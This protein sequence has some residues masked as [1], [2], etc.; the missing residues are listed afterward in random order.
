MASGLDGV[1]AAETVLSLVDGANGRLVV[2]GKE[3]AE[4]VPKY[5]FEGT[6]ALL[7]DGFVPEGGNRI[8]VQAGLGTAREAAFA[9]VSA[10][11]AAARGLPPIE[12]LRVGLALLGDAEPSPHYLLATGALPVFL[13]ALLRAADGKSPVAPDA[14]LT[15]AADFLRMLRDAPAPAAEAAALDAYLTTVAEHGLNA[16]TFT[17]R[18]VASTRAGTISAVLGALC[19]LKGPLH[20][21]APEPVLDMLDEIGT[22]ERARPWLEA[23]ISKGE[24]LMG[25][26][27]RIYKVRDPRA[28]VLKQVV[29][30]MPRSGNRIA[31]AE[32]VE[33]EALA[34]LK[35]LKPGRKLETNVEF[36]TALLLDAVGLP[37]QAFTPV[38]AVARAVGW[39]AHIMEQDRLGRLVR[40]ESRY[41]GP[42]LATAA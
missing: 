15:T 33:R 28:D 10:L 13:A 30:G 16:S 21:G 7:W 26:G 20:G 1:V 24:R 25:F 4:L 23:A 32:A 42:P 40:P 11:L 27:H 9:H 34:A 38:F 8:A 14:R 12:A 36:Y 22:V 41:I 35:R 37:R 19:A 6:A 39:S 17:A 3:L 31:F 5:G 18:V 29:L 2:R